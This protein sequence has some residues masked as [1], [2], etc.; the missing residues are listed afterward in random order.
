MGVADVDVALDTSVSKGLY[1]SRASTVLNRE[2][3]SAVPV[4]S[5]PRLTAGTR[6]VSNDGF[7]RLCRVERL[8]M[9][10]SCAVII[11]PFLRRDFFVEAKVAV[12]TDESSRLML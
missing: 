4:P 9:L 3:M 6:N 8:A 12:R 10:P 2:L 5:Q 1:D 11:S 7:G